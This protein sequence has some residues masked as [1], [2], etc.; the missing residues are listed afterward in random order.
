MTQLGLHEPRST[1]VSGVRGVSDEPAPMEQRNGWKEVKSAAGNKAAAAGTKG[2]CSSPFS[3]HA[4][5]SERLLVLVQ[6]YYP[7]L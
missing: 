4:L 2:C 5:S 3:R 1:N 6:L 7:S